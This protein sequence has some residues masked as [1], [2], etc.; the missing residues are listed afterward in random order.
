MDNI[1]QLY[2]TLYQSTFCV[3]AKTKQL[4]LTFFKPFVEKLLADMGKNYIIYVSTSNSNI[5]T[6]Q[7]IWPS[8]TRLQYIEDDFIPKA[9]PTN[10]NVIYFY[11]QKF[12]PTKE[13][14]LS[15]IEYVKNH[16]QLRYIYIGSISAL[17]PIM[18]IT[19]FRYYLHF[20]EN[21]R[22]WGRISTGLIV[23]YKI[24]RD[25]SK[26]Y[27]SQL[28]RKKKATTK[29][30]LY[31][32]FICHDLAMDVT[33]I[34]KF[35]KKIYQ[36]KVPKIST[37]SNQQSGPKVVTKVDV[38]YIYTNSHNNPNNLIMPD[39]TKENYQNMV[40]K[41]KDVIEV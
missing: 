18:R 29:I 22:R 23:S 16:P 7:S 26:K 32:F 39:G 6:Y 5:P 41:Y 31:D 10:I 19:L 15:L 17:L 25:L 14:Q 8:H 13:E 33:N 12:K 20:Q 9:I 37:I 40:Q 21:K 3:N 2:N 38:K 35:N 30:T 27:Y 24:T 4:Y 34:Y 28:E 11:H 36:P 1:T